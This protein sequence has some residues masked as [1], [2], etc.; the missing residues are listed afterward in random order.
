MST[1][2]HSSHLEL[3]VVVMLRMARAVVDGGWWM[4]WIKPMQGHHW[5]RGCQYVIEGVCGSGPFFAQKKKYTT[6]YIMAFK[7][8]G[9]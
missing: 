4:W 2:S 9:G 5:M 3:L 8:N 1:D 7:S 6:L